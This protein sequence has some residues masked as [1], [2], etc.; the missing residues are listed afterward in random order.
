MASAVWV[1]KS[2]MDGM[3]IPIG[4][5]YGI[6]ANIW[7]ILM[8][9]VTIYGIHGSYGIDQV[10]SSILII[11]FIVFPCQLGGGTSRNCHSYWCLVCRIPNIRRRPDI[12]NSRVRDR[13]APMASTCLG[14]GPHHRLGTE[15]KWMGNSL[16][17]HIA[18]RHG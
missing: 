7:G 17:Q 5:M 11:V 16:E 2:K 6:Y 9:N 12:L 13:M 8:V 18:T 3:S 4:S 10:T 14:R 15:Q 1:T